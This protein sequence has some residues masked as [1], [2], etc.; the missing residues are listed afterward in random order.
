MLTR[1]RAAG[2]I[3]AT[4]RRRPRTRVR[5]GTRRP[6]GSVT[7]TRP[8][9]KLSPP[10]TPTEIALSAGELR[11]AAT[12]NVSL[13]RRLPTPDSLTPETVGGPATRQAKN[14]ARSDRS[15]PS[16]ATPDSQLPIRLGRP[17]ISP[18]DDEIDRPGGSWVGKR[19]TPVRGPPATLIRS[20]RVGPSV[21]TSG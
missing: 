4:S 8:A 13:G 7:V 14:A 21:E 5:A 6:L 15:C 20:E 12:M 16:A 9:A 11:P 2:I 18:V 17:V 19:R 1:M 3:S 10:D